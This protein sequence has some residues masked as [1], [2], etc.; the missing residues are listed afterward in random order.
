MDETGLIHTGIEF[1]GDDKKKSQFA[2]HLI[3]AHQFIQDS[4]IPGDGLWYL[5]LPIAF[6][7]I[8]KIMSR[9]D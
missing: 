8:S 4:N 2:K 7:D 3:K 1:V 9:V 5:F 6:N